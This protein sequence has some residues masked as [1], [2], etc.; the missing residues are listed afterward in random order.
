MGFEGGISSAYRYLVHLGM[1]AGQQG[2]K[3]QPRRL[4][5]HQAAWL[6][7][8]PEKKLDGH[9]KRY[10][11]IL[12]KISPK[13]LEA[14]NLVNSFVKMIQEKQSNQ[15]STWLENAQN[16]SIPKLR[17]FAVGISADYLAVQSALCFDWS[18]GHLEGQ[19]NR[20]KTLKRMM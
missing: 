16:S 15:L 14:S 1:Q 17:S 5:A 4:T 3:L 10:Q 20:L 8:T 13:V 19:I 11:D 7:T 18:N 9:Q 12:F 2:I 6:L